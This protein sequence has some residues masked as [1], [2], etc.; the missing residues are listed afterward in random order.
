MNRKD[1]ILRILSMKLR[2]YLSDCKLNYEYLQEIRLRINQPV[3]LVYKNEP[4]FL[5]YDGK[6]GEDMQK[7]VIIYEK[8]LRETMEYISNYSMYAY[9]DELKQG[10][11]T[12]QGGH[13]VGIAGKTTIENGKIKTIRHIAF[14][15]IRVAHEVKDCSI[16]ILPYIKKED[17]IYH[18][19]II[20]PPRCGKTT[21]L[22]DL[23]RLLSQ[24]YT[25]GVVDERS[26]I[27]ASYQGVPQ[28]DVGPRTD[29]L[30]CCPKCE[31]M[32]ILLRSMSPEIIAVDEI[33]SEADT[34]E[35]KHIIYSG[36]RVLATVHGDTLADIIKKPLWNLFE[37]FVVLKG[38]REAGFV[39]GIY[40]QQENNIWD[41]KLWR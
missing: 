28:N 32:R 8:E 15:N 35:L 9:E 39:E 14:I 25:I 29:L 1:E 2:K 18:T 7:A 19:L 23:I 20:S 22:R 24:E 30:D 38:R 37:R 6:L 26:E 4:C 41:D 3:Q 12:V 17:G 31:G 21:I 5:Y 16:G 40:D 27:G 34:E 10:F 13:R 33:G 11:I 36:C